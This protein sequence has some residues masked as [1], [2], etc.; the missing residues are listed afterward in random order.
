[1]KSENNLKRAK[2]NVFIKFQTRYICT[3]GPFN[4]SRERIEGKTRERPNI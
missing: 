1:L 2:N 3:K 4:E